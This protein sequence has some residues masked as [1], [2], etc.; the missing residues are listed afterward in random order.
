MDEVVLLQHYHQGFD[1]WDILSWVKNPKY[2][3]KDEIYCCEGK[4]VLAAGR[5]ANTELNVAPI[6]FW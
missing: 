6:H 1:R 3:D 4:F 2:A 5:G